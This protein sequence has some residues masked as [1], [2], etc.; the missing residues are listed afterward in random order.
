MHAPQARCS[1]RV[2]GGERRRPAGRIRHPAESSSVKVPCKQNPLASMQE[3]GVVAF[4]IL[5][6]RGRGGHNL[7][8]IPIA[9][10]LL[11]FLAIS[12]AVT[13]SL[14]LIVGSTL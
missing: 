3:A 13:P 7:V 2:G 4:E 14:D 8:R 5:T 11:Y 10:W 1:Q 12:R 9:G 6:T